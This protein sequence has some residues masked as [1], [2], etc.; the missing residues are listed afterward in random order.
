M[1]NYGE[2]LAYW[3]L[4]LNGFFPITNFVLHSLKNKR[5]KTP[6]IADAD[7]L[8]IRPPNASEEIGGL[9]LKYDSHTDIVR[10]DEASKYI[11]VYCEVKTGDSYKV[12]V[13][14]PERIEYARKRFGLNV[15]PQ[16]EDCENHIDNIFKKVLI[17]KRKQKNV[18]NDDVDVFISLDNDAIP[19]IRNRFKEY[20]EYKYPSRMFFNSSLIQLLIH[21]EKQGKK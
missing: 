5:L 10:S 14:P 20:D 3:Y 9:R 1:N 4:R 18:K 19:F 13:F 6:Y 8:A 15:E 16:T 17:A 21:E 11:F 2:E 7:I 12:P